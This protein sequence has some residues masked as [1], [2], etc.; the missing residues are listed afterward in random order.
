MTLP[1]PGVHGTSNNP[2][3]EC[4]DNLVRYLRSRKSSVTSGASTEILPDRLAWY[5]AGSALGLLVVGLFL[6]V[7]QPLGASGAYVQTIKAVRRDS[8]TIGWRVW[9]PGGIFVGG[10]M[11]ALLRSGVDLRTG[12]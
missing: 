3:A 10:L 11:A 9:Y 2:I 1:D 4:T 12:V 5:L 6:V 8:D 7:N